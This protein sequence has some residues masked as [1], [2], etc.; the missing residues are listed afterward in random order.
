[1]VGG[2][3]HRFSQVNYA[4]GAAGGAGGRQ[5]GSSFKPIVLAAALEAGIDID[6]TYSAPACIQPEG[7]LQPVCNA[8]GRGAGSQ[9]LGAA[10]VSSTNTVYIQLI[11]DVGVARTANLANRMGVTSLDASTATGGIAIGVAEVAPIEMAGA[12]ATFAAGGI[13]A[14]PSP[15]QRVVAADGTVLFDLSTRGVRR[16]MSPETARA[17]NDTLGA[18]SPTAPARTPTSVGRR[19]A[20]RG[21]PTTT[22]TPGSWATPR[23]WPPRCGSATP[24]APS[25]SATSAAWPGWAAAPSRRPSGAST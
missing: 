10:M 9:T 4:L 6:A 8:N 7:F 1:M 5:P 11:G 17:V 15:V 2:R 18:V 25:P 24:R 19:R 16:V 22:S 13:Y 20:R 3:D 23:S 21:P 14:E 12:Y